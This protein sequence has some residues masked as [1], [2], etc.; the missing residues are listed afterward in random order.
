MKTLL[1]NLSVVG[2]LLA[3]PAL[4]AQQNDVESRAMRDEMQRSVK[5]LHIESAEK[6]YYIAYKIV[7]T[8][9]KEAQASLGALTSSSESR[10][11]S[12]VVIVRVGD[13]DFD[14]TGSTTGTNIAEV[15]GSLS[16]GNVVLPLDDNYEELRRKIWLATDAAYKRA[17][18][19][20]SAKKA[21]EQ[22][23]NHDQHTP[24]F[25]KEPARQ[26][27]EIR[28]PVVEKLADAENLVRAASA[29]FRTLPSVETSNAHFGIV[30]ATERFL[31]SEGT[32]YLRQTALLSFR[33]SVSVQYKNGETFSDSCDEYGRSIDEMPKDTALIEE[34]KAVADRLAARLH[35]RAAKR[36]NGPVLLEEQSAA[37]LFAHNFV[38]L[39]STHPHASSGSSSGLL[40]MLS[41]ST[42]SLLDKMGSR[43]LPDFLT[44]LDNPQLTRIDG[45][46][47]IGDYKFDEEATP[48]QETVLIRNG[49][50]KTLL[51]SR[52]PVH[53]IQVSTGNSRSSGVL[54]GNLIVSA[55]TTLSKSELRAKLLDLVKTRGLE[56]GII[57]KRLS[58]NTAIEASR[59]Y[60][61]GHE[62]AL[63][64]AKVAGISAS[65]FKDILAVSSE[66][67]VYNQQ[68]Q[69]TS[70]L[71]FS[72][73]AV[74]DLVSYVAPAMLFEDMT[75]DHLSTSA[76]KPP[77]VQSPLAVQ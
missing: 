17:V 32:T 50:L 39:L 47:L 20:Y 60:P 29:V 68:V 18:E 4:R 77:V 54:P 5:E 40:A 8:D 11:R 67:T 65:T 66:R 13:Y 33:A 49:I 34:A 24:D 63:R 71:N 30:N 72:P 44:V 58:G 3:S 59:I 52:T 55:T 14:N 38:S 37:E 12:L 2:M 51:T 36:Y 6:P 53:E 25:I 70:I 16:N 42:A 1:L 19:Q 21:A 35:G 76:P 69:F 41:G 15:L 26:E 31:N 46:A 45:H 22:N 56:Y 61:D 75:V 62:E 7:D 27:S 10:N 57:I 23:K 74:G 48:T 28:P 9:R 43:V 73:S 64:D